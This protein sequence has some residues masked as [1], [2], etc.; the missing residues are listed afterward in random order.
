V[1]G[2]DSADVPTLLCCL[3]RSLAGA[4]GAAVVDALARLTGNDAQHGGGGGGGGGECADAGCGMCAAR[5]AAGTM[6]GLPSCAHRG[7]VARGELKLKVCARCGRVAYCSRA[8]QKEDWARHR[9]QECVA[10]AAATPA[11]SV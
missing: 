10:T 11:A 1:A 2:I 9:R 6:C 7:E 5:R 4:G 3:S 8:C